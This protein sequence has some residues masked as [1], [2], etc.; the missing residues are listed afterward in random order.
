LCVPGEV[1]TITQ[2]GACE[3]V[4]EPAECC[5][6]PDASCLESN[7]FTCLQYGR[8][9]KLELPPPGQAV[10]SPTVPDGKSIDNL[11]STFNFGV[12]PTACQSACA[13]GDCC[14]A[15]GATNC[16]DEDPL[17]CLEYSPCK[18]F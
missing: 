6:D 3:D 18:V 7:F 15:S 8:C 17:G 14:S 11:C 5:W 16:F 13:D 10:T 2:Q 1:E 12:D 9:E 4:C